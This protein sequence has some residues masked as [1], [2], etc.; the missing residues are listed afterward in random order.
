VRCLAELKGTGTLS[1]EMGCFAM[2]SKAVKGTR[3][4]RPFAPLFGAGE[5]EGV[6]GVG[7]GHGQGGE[8]GLELP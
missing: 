2:G 7:R 4:T 8:E 6:G 5:S 3:L 1:A